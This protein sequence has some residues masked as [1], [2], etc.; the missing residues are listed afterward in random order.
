MSSKQLFRRQARWSK[1]LSCFNF[2]IS[3]R[4]GAQ[5]KADALTKRSQDLP[6][7]SNPRQDFIGQVVLKPKNLSSLEPIC[8]LC[9]ED[10]MPIEALDQDL[11]TIISQAYQDIDPKDP[12]AFISQMI[13]NEE[14]HSCQYFL[15]D[16]SLDNR[17]LY[18][19]GKLYLPNHKSLHLWI[20]QESHNQPMTRHP[21]VARTYEILQHSYYWL[22]MVNLV[23]QYI[24]DCHTCS[25]AKLA[26]NRQKKLL[27]LPVPSQP[28]KD[29]AMDFITELPV[30]TDACY[31][32]S[33][34]I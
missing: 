21:G 22:K 15:L 2:K 30:S 5:C 9:H 24:R 19:Y 28:W 25:R 1:F 7:D 33:R 31:P 4:P 12:V 23:R 27:P 10:I 17:H 6:A 32:H 14:R 13:M 20:L 8:I 3:Y 18:H 29:F 16:Y 34:H 26:K 11:E